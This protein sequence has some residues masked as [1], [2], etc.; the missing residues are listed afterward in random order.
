VRLTVL[1]EAGVATRLAGGAGPCRLT[2]A[3][4][5]LVVSAALVAM[6]LT[7]CD[8]DIDAGAV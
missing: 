6:T 2:V 8:D 4:A 1:V 3:V 5:V 7:F